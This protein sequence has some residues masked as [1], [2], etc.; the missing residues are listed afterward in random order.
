MR[1]NS[2]LLSAKKR[3]KKESVI[4]TRVQVHMTLTMALSKNFGLTS[5]LILCDLFVTSTRIVGW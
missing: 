1:L 2:R 4:V 5:K 3:G